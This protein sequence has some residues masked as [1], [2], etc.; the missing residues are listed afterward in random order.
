MVQKFTSVSPNINFHVKWVPCHHGMARSQVAVGGEGL[1][2]LSV[3]ASIWISSREQPTNGGPAA[4]GLG[5]VL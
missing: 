2:I 3:A 5:V 1:Q 4:W